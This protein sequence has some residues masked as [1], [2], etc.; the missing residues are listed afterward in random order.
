MLDNRNLVI[1]TMSEVYAEL[2]PYAIAEFWNFSEHEPIPN[3]VY[4]LGR[5]QVVENVDKFKRLAED[6]AYTMVFGNSAEGSST[7]IAQLRVLGLEELVL[8]NKILLISG[9]EL[10]TQYPYMLHEHFLIRILDYEENIE[11]MKRTE[12]IFSKT[13]KP[14]KFLFLNGRARPHRKYLWEHFKRQGLLDNSLWTVLD[15]RPTVVRNFN[16]YEGDVNVMATN[17]P[18]QS[19]PTQYEVDRYRNDQR[20]PDE[21]SWAG[22]PNRTFVKNDL[23]NNQWGE[24]YLNADPYIDTY[25]SIVT[26][27]VY[28]Y[29]Y[30]FR[31]EKIAKPL[32]MG[33]PWI[34][35]T[36]RGWYR[37]IQ[38]LGFQTFGHVIDESFDLIENDQDRMNRIITVVQDL[39]QQDLASFL[40]ECY[41]ICKY[42]QQHLAEMRQQVRQEFPNRFKQFIQQHL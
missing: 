4:V 25:F 21:W 19:L 32:A 8:N 22:P 39:C 9:G 20:D 34:C 36:S 35:A 41:N 17:T 11:Q 16:F 27:T 42:N 3:S 2:S 28:D 7:L 18:L 5:Q 13:N 15:S 38:N 12:E 33:H 29:P 26:E 30:S 40:Q 14:Y 1:D 37:D 24:I 23:F 31:T 10:E 6:P